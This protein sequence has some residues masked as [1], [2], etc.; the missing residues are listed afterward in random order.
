MKRLN[1]MPAL[2]ALCLTLCLS[3]CA[4]PT[5]PSPVVLLPP[6]AVFTP[7]EQPQLSG[8]T[9]G[10]AVDY[11]LALQAALRLCAGRVAALN[12]WRTGL[13]AQ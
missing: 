12:L 4:Q 3:S 13:P 9:W 6:E 8:D 7:C 5:P 2:A 10:E 1:M 11:T